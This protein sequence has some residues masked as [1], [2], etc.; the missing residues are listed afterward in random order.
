MTTMT[1]ATVISPFAND[2][3]YALGIADAY[4]EHQAG[5]TIDTLKARASALLD[6]D[7]PHTGHIQPAE[8]YRL[9]YATSIAGLI[10]SHIATV[11]AQSDVAHNTRTQTG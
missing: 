9:G 8:L 3:F 7:Y 6:A 1:T 2:P 5:E 4:D 10:R 11:N